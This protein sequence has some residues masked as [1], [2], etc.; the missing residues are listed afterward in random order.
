MKK[1][2]TIKEV[3]NQMVDKLSEDSTETKYVQAIENL[4]EVTYSHNSI[5][6]EEQLKACNSVFKVNIKNLSLEI[7][8]K[9]LRG[10]IVKKLNEGKDDLTNLQMTKLIIPFCILSIE[11]R[12]KGI[13]TNK[14]ATFLYEKV[15]FWLIDGDTIKEI[16]IGV[17]NLDYLKKK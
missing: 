15:D 14:R 11:D 12:N 10:A 4:L 3:V 2:L 1:G 7:M 16:L 17:S 5:H 6:K 13:R 9:K 8:K